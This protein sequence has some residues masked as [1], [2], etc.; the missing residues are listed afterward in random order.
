M[1]TFNKRLFL[2]IGW[3]GEPDYTPFIFTSVIDE[4]LKTRIA[5]LVKVLKVTDAE[6]IEITV[7][8]G[9][10]SCYDD[11]EMPKTEKQSQREVGLINADALDIKQ[12]R[13]II[14]EEGFEFETFGEEGDSLLTSDIVPFC[15]LADDKPYHSDSAFGALMLCRNIAQH[16][17][18]EWE[19]REAINWQEAEDLISSIKAIPPRVRNL[20]PELEPIIYLSAVE[21]WDSGMVA[22]WPEQIIKAI[23]NFFRQPVPVTSV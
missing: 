13:L 2:T 19:A 6:A 14:R 7:K 9:V 1:S 17:E 15:C 20:V 21:E 8:D 11:F 18:N 12:T 22:Q 23:S 16:C 3:I 5:K 10:W 4:A